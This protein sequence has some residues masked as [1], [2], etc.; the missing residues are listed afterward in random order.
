MKKYL[1]LFV[2]AMT[3]FACESNADVKED[4]ESLRKERTVMIEYVAGYVRQ[5][6]LKR[7]R[8]LH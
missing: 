7:V 3:L 4:I 6:T 2:A 5:N 1:L 8:L